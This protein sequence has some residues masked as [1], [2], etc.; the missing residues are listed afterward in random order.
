[1]QITYQLAGQGHKRRF[2]LAPAGAE[3]AV[4]HAIE[5]KH[6][7]PVAWRVR[8][9]TSGKKDSPMPGKEILPDLG[10]SSFPDVNLEALPAPWTLSQP[11][12]GA[13]RQILGRP[14][15]AS[16]CPD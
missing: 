7:E 4:R 12:E 6:G 14:R 8:R 3:R 2:V 10:T 15:A 11:V 5:A 16:G 13:R 9:L 1:M